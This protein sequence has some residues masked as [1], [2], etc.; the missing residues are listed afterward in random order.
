MF[1]TILLV[2]IS[3]PN[4]RKKK[5]KKEEFNFNL[6]TRAHTHTHTPTRKKQTSVA[7]LSAQRNLTLLHYKHHRLDTL[8]VFH[9]GVQIQ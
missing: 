3:T 4:S 9:E 7:F 6:H 2:Q 8:E 5:K 1:D